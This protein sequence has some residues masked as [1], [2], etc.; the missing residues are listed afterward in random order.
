MYPYVSD[1]FQDLFGFEWPLPFPLNSFGL[2]VAL[3]LLTATWLARI[4]LDRLYAR[5]LIAPVRA[6]VPDAK[7]RERERDV[8][9]SF[10]I[11]TLMGISA[12]AGI[13]G[14]KLFNIIDFWEEFVQ[15]PIGTIFSGSGLTFYGGLILASISVA[16]YAHRKGIHVPRLADSIAPGLLGAYGIGRIGCYLSGDGDW[17]L[18]SSLVDKPGWVPGWLYSETFPR[19]FV[20][21][22]RLVGDEVVDIQDPVTFNELVRGVECTVANATGVLPTMLYEFVLCAALGGGLWLLR[23][24]PFKAGWLFSLFLVIQGL[25]RFLI[26]FIRTNREWAFGLSQS[27]WISIGLMTAGVIGLVMLTRRVR[28]GWGDPPETATE[29][30]PVAAA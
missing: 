11:W 16:W 6:K 28:P 9:P 18:C 15:N 13:V 23:K 21:G 10:Y 20:Y 4:E 7:G 5:G 26:E 19:A 14:S 1:I 27:Q 25:E 17:G 29:A 24:H 12:V 3:A 30:E 2:M 22:P 8:S